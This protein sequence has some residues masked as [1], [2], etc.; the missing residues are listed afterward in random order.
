[1]LIVFG[2]VGLMLKGEF[3]LS[4]M[5]HIESECLGVNIPENKIYSV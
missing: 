3:P 2:A 5:G 4:Q 1:M